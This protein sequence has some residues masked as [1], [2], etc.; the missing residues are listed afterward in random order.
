[1]NKKINLFIKG[2]VKDN[3]KHGKNISK[4][5]TELLRLAIYNLIIKGKKS[6]LRDW[7]AVLYNAEGNEL[8]ILYYLS[9]IIP[10]SKK[11][12]SKLAIR[13]YW[14][15][16]NIIPIDFREIFDPIRFDATEGMQT[17]DLRLY[18]TL[19]DMTVCKPL[20]WTANHNITW[21]KDP[22]AYC[23]CGQC[24]CTVL[25]AEIFKKDILFCRQGPFGIEV[26]IQWENMKVTKSFEVN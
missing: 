13:A 24:Y 18:N 12:Y 23:D 1:M 19:S 26:A 2:Y 6:I 10:I 25:E 14:K 15:H 9:K 17:A 7:R 21:I 3:R 20:H 22:T 8:F 11:W 16:K 5:K 4:E